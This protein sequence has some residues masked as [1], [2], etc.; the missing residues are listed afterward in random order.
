MAIERPLVSF[1]IG[2]YFISRRYNAVKEFLE[3]SRSITPEMIN[4]Q[5]FISDYENMY[6]CAIDVGQDAFWVAEPFCGIPWMEAIFGCEVYSTKSSFIAL[7]PKT[8]YK[9]ESFIF[10]QENKWL[11]D[12]P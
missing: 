9:I 10:D 4:V 8:V 3:T 7:M 1:Q 6:K 2:D 11:V 5:T 12:I